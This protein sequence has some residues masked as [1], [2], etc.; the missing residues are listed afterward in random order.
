MKIAFMVSVLVLGSMSLISADSYAHSGGTNA[1]GCHTNR[2][3]GDYHCHTRKTP[4]PNTQTYCH[5]VNNERRCGYARQTCIELS[6]KY[7][8]RCTIE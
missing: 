1:A 5:I 4:S 2:K 7:G 8:G 3:T 6:E